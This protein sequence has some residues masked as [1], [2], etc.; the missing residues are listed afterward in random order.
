MIILE[1][2]SFDD[3]HVQINSKIYLTEM[4]LSVL[5]LREIFVREPF[6]RKLQWKLKSWP[7]FLISLSYSHTFYT[8]LQASFFGEG[9]AELAQND[10]SILQGM[11]LLATV[12]YCGSSV[13]CNT[14]P[15]NLLPAPGAI[16]C[17]AHPSEQHLFAPAH[18]ESFPHS[19]FS[20]SG[21]GHSKR[22]TSLGQSPCFTE[23]CPTKNKVDTDPIEK[24]L[25]AL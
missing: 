11:N 7:N 15:T 8:F 17:L 21:G 14:T 5:K 9:E 23:C 3:E 6:A 16:H 25:K 19:W 2:M 12:N 13:H 18:C 4:G 10:I 22:W 20:I 1:N 24:A